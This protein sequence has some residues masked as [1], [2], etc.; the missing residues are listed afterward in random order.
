MMA[1]LEEGLQPLYEGC[2]N[3]RNNW[4]TM[5]EEYAKS[6]EEE[7]KSKDNANNNQAP[8]PSTERKISNRRFS[9]TE[10]RLWCWLLFVMLLGAV[11]LGCAVISLAATWCAVGSGRRQ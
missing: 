7:E 10:T 9:F 8:L 4:Q 3:N 1:E 5:H 2:I 6:L 11:V